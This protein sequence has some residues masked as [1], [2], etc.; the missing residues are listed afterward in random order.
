M[1]RKDKPYLPLYVQDFMTDERLREC[2]ASATGVYIMIMCVMHKS[3]NYGTILLQQKDKQ[4]DHQII[5]FASKL[6]RHLPFNLEVISTGLQELVHEKCLFIDGDL[7]F[8]KRMVSDGNLSVVRADAGSKGGKTT[9]NNNKNF[10][11]AKIAAN[12]DIDNEI[13][14]NKNTLAITNGMWTQV[15]KDWGN[16]F[17]WKEKFCRDK[18]V[19]M[20]LLESKM[21]EFV[22]ELE[23]KEDIKP[24]KELKSHFVNTYNKNLFKPIH[25]NGRVLSPYEQDLENKRQLAKGK[26]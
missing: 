12:T 6:L 15:V 26:I 21:A 18:K 16:D 10:A 19:S 24:L 2:S 20:P 4:S 1:A 9:K 22:N 5:N 8:Q 3:E 23:L 25:G 14:I 11:T 13:D 17:N 7:L